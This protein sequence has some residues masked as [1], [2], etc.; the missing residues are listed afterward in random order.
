V[1][2]T[3]LVRLLDADPDLGIGL[4]ADRLQ[5]ARR[6]LVAEVALIPA[7]GSIDAAYARADPDR[8]LGLLILDGVV[9]RQVRLVGETGVEL[10][11]A[12][13]LIRP[14]Q[15][16]ADFASVPGES[17][18]RVC[19]AAQV[20]LLDEDV[21]EALAG[22]PSIASQITARL[23]Q[24]SNTLALL[25]AVAQLPRLDSRLLAVL[26]HLADRFGR[27]EPGGI[28]V[29]LR[30]SH[31]TLA[32]LV[33]A[34]RPSVTTALGR[35]AEAGAVAR[36]RAGHLKLLGDPPSEDRL[37]APPPDHDDTRFARPR[38]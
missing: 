14:W 15:A 23:V 5:A 17:S 27:V 30:L 12:G 38:G 29:P 35:L 33:R 7:G 3:Q 11:A 9:M 13:D 34:R 6:H 28:V 19:E 1:P 16:P 26:W 20:A 18:W 22:F 25:L 21:L 2:V 4:D 24:R 10:L 31:G 8:L 32:T 36:T 37:E